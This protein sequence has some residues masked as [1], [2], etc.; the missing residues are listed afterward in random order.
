MSSPPRAA[1]PVFYLRSILH[2]AVSPPLPYNSCSST[3]TTAPR[4]LPAVVVLPLCRRSFIDCRFVVVV[5]SAVVAPLPPTIRR[6][7]SAAI[8]LQTVTPPTQPPHPASLQPSSLSAF[9]AAHLLIVV[10]CHC[11]QRHCSPSAANRPPRLFSPRRPPPHP[12]IIP[13]PPLCVLRVS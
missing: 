10:F 5:I 12:T 6:V 4:L 2:G 8:V 13:I 1:Q 9:A 7:S 3:S 11:R